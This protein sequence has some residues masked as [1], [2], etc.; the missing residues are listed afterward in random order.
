[1]STD[2]VIVTGLFKNREETLAAVQTIQ[3][4]GWQV[5]EVH[6]PIPDP[7]LAQALGRKKSKVG[8]F[9]LTGGIIG[10]FSGFLLAVFTA[11]RWNLMVSGKPILSWIPFFVIAFEFTI[12]FAIFG[13]VLGILTQVGLPDKDY[14]KNYDPECSGSLYGI[15]VASPPKEVAGLKDL[16]RRTGSLKDYKETI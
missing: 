15:E 13:N 4:Q 3:E 9:T 5:K 10:F 12:L 7:E 2:A 8:W 16:L 11:T 1:M 6:S 14:E